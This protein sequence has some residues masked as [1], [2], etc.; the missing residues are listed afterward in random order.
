M[1]LSFSLASRVV[2]YLVLLFKK[3]IIRFFPLSTNLLFNKFLS[4][5]V[6]VMLYFYVGGIVRNLKL[7]KHIFSR[8]V[9]V[10]A[11]LAEGLFV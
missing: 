3:L 10:Q 6:G 5:F 9:E 7:E 8:T 1:C 11:S 2:Y 4:A